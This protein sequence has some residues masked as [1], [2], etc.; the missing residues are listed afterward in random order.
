MGC[1][2]R[3]PFKSHNAMSTAAIAEMAT[4]VRPTQGADQHPRIVYLPQDVRSPE[5]LERAAGAAA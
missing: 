4:D 1:P 5:L 3:F 2:K